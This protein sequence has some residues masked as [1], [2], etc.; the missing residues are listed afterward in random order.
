V[1]CSSSYGSGP[2]SAVNPTSISTPDSLRVLN[3]QLDERS[4]SGTFLGPTV[5][6][7]NERPH[8][9]L[10]VFRWIF[11]TVAHRGLRGYSAT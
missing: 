11:K 6:H 7:V 1:R 5:V 8:A 3:D 10:D 9:L 4:P 2:D